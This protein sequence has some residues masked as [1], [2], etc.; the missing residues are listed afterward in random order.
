MVPPSSLLC[1]AL[2]SKTSLTLAAL[3]V[4]GSDDEV[5]VKEMSVIKLYRM[6]KK[7]EEERKG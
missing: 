2:P 1:Q 4:L 7:V 3:P 5:L 6:R